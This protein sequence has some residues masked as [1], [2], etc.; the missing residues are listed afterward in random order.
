V[1]RVPAMKAPAAY[2]EY[3]P[4]ASACP[5]A[6]RSSMISMRRGA[7]HLEVAQEPLDLGDIDGFG[8]VVIES[9]IS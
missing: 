2:V 9:R 4:M 8:K 5:L 1:M 6:G 7:R 3:R